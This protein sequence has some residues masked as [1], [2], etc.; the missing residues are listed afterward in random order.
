MYNLCDYL[1]YSCVFFVFFSNNVGSY[2]PRSHLSPT[3]L[4]KIL[5]LTTLVTIIFFSKFSI[6][7]SS[8]KFLVL[9]WNNF[10]VQNICMFTSKTSYY[11]CIVLAFSTCKVVLVSIYILMIGLVMQPCL[12][13]MEKKNDRSRSPLVLTFHIFFTAILCNMSHSNKNK[14]L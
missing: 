12:K 8:K 9:F 1:T 7:C 11:V 10:G 6:D 13:Y 3:I 2:D 4:R 5:I 14:K